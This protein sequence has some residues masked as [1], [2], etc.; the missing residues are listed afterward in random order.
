MEDMAIEFGDMLKETLVRCNANMCMRKSVRSAGRDALSCALVCVPVFVHV[1][2]CAS[3]SWHVRCIAD[4]YTHALVRQQ[5]IPALYTWGS[6]YNSM[7]AFEIFVYMYACVW[8]CALASTMCTVILLWKI[9]LA[10]FHNNK[11]T[12]TKFLVRAF[13]YF[14]FLHASGQNKLCIWACV[15]ICN[16]VIVGMYV[17]LWV[18]IDVCVCVRCVYARSGQ[19]RDICTH[20]CICVDVCMYVCIY[21]FSHSMCTHLPTRTPHTHAYMHT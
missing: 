10:Y 13:S 16:S 5:H 15:C 9:L 20:M 7:C 21:S 11:H 12:R 3:A 19:D 2:A 14:W 8:E 1:H 18:Y 6:G 17:C 4:V